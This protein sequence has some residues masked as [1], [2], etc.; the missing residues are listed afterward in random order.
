MSVI[1]SNETVVDGE[2][3]TLERIDP[4]P[5][6][7]F[8]LTTPTP[9][10]QTLFDSHMLGVGDVQRPRGS[11]P[12]VAVAID[13]ETGKPDVIVAVNREVDLWV[14]SGMIVKSEMGEI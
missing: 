5:G 13:D 4:I 8:E 10:N 11:G 12:I 14:R 6:T 2:I 1:V 9:S 7:T 3:V